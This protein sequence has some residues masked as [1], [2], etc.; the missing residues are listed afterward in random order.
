MGEM[1]ES[2]EQLSVTL[3]E[4]RTARRVDPQQAQRMQQALGRVGGELKRI[5]SEI[6]DF[7]NRME[8]VSRDLSRTKDTVTQHLNTVSLALTAFFVCFAFSQLSLFFQ[9]VRLFRRRATRT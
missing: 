8:K 2:L 9:G 3:A 4:I 5:E 6:T 7:T 1:S